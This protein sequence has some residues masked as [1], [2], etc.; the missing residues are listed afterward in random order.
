MRRVWLWLHRWLGLAVGVPFCLIALSGAIY[1][2]EPELRAVVQQQRVPERDLPLASVTELRDAVQAALPQGDLRTL[3]WRESGWAVEALVYAPGTYFH[4]QLDPYD[5]TVVHVQDMKVGWVNRLRDL[6]RTLLLGEPGRR[7]G[8]A[9]VTI[10]FGLILTGV[11]LRRPWRR[12]ATAL[13]RKGGW[14]TWHLR[15]GYHGSVVALL[16]VMTGLYWAHDFIEHGFKAATGELTQPVPPPQS[17]VPAEGAPRPAAW[18]L[19]QDLAVTMRAEHP[20]ANVRVSVPHGDRTP[21]TV[22]II[23]RDHRVVTTVVRQFDRYTGEPIVRPTDASNGDSR[24]RFNR[25]SGWVYDIH[26]GTWLG[27]PGRLM[28]CVSALL[29]A[30]LP[31]SGV[32]M[33]WRGRSGK[34]S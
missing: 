18:P 2:W 33:W 4:V 22:S 1:C 24:S 23:Q 19:L 32:V 3:L 31:V 6:H 20:A 34:R 10:Y 17:V 9:V 5:A 29:A 14:F 25:A 16:S 26:F 12:N 8:H 30:S 21:I 13:A 28:M 7:I 27:F 11:I 15:L